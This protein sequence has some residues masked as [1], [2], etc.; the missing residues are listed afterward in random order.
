MDRVKKGVEKVTKKDVLRVAKEYLQPDK[1]QILVVG[2][3]EDFDKPL[4]TLGE[5]N[6]IDIKI[7]PAKPKKPKKK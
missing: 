3:Q 5:V 6:T 1:V 7:P 4:S 2:K